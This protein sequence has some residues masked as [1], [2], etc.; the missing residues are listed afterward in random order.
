MTLSV[1]IQVASFK[2]TGKRVFKITPLQH[3]FEMVGWAES[4]I[5]VRFWLIAGMFVALG[6]RHLLHWLVSELTHP[7]IA[8]VGHGEFGI[9]KASGASSVE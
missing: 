7:P 9:C 1:V 4:M 6:A 8:V 5:M 3:H 2:T